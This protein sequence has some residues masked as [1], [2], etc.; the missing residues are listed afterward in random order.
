MT[1]TKL[2]QEQAALKQQLQDIA[3]ASYGK[4]ISGANALESFQEQFGVFKSTAREFYE[5]EF[6]YLDNEIQHFSVLL[7]GAGGGS[8]SGSDRGVASSSTVNS[9]SAG[10]AAAESSS[11]SSAAASISVAAQARKGNAE[12]IILL[13]NFD[14]IQDMLEL[15][16]L[17]LAC[18]NKGYY[19]EVLDLAAHT[20]RLLL[21]Y[22][23]VKV[24]QDIHKQVESALETM[25]VQLLRLLRE[26]VKLP[27][28]IKV[29]SYLRRMHP[30]Q[31]ASD[32]GRHL[33]QLYLVSRL[34]YIRTLLSTL[35]PLKRQSPEV[36]LKRTIEVF[37]EH[38]F[39][40]VVGFRSVFP[41]S[42]STTANGAA[43]TTTTEK[44]SSS[45]SSAGER[46]IASFL[47]TNVDELHKTI[48]DISPFID[49]ENARNGLWL[50]VSY[51]SQSLGRVGGDFWPTVQGSL[52]TGSGGIT[53]E[54]WT[55]ALK[56]QKEVSRHLGSNASP[57][58]V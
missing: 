25:L 35:E 20:N 10:V 26:T 36:Y 28:L 6:V 40:T 12:A 13:K 52:E 24:I 46:L 50:Q 42:L 55:T 41:D 18:V 16:M 19:T 31:S 51:C 47:R 30:F 9:S 54:E 15:P 43:T 49:D 14:K 44:S 8:G 39:V 37:R 56:K 53:R 5:E 23:S 33:Q 1:E 45:S 29:M 48:S 11:S 3:Q 38:V 22:S 21:R 2:E 57:M 58:I 27:S 34:Q 17:T 7:G 32:V 4:F